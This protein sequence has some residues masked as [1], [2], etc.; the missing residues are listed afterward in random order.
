MESGSIGTES[1]LIRWT[2]PVGSVA[3]ILLER[4]TLSFRS[5]PSHTD[6][7]LIGIHNQTTGYLLG[8][9][10]IGEIAGAVREM[11]N[12]SCLCAFCEL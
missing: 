6:W 7:T 1:R 2:T 4:H 3:S 5:L 12:R 10:A 8:P 9:A 11:R